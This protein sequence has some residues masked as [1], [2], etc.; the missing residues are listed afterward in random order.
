MFVVADADDDN[1][2]WGFRVFDASK[3]WEKHLNFQIF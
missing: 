2:R 3:C 1:D